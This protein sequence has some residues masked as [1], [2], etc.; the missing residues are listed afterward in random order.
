MADPDELEAP[1]HLGIMSAMSDGY[2]YYVGYLKQGGTSGISS[3]F[4]SADDLLSPGSDP[5]SAPQE[6]GFDI[7]KIAPISD[8]DAGKRIMF[9]AEAVNHDS[10]RFLGSFSVEA[11]TG[12]YGEDF[13]EL[14]RVGISN[15]A[16]KS[17]LKH[18]TCVNVY[19]LALNTGE[20]GR[21]PSWFQ[22]FIGACT[23]MIDILNFGPKV[24]QILQPYTSTSEEAAIEKAVTAV[25]HTLG[26]GTLQNIAS[27]PLREF[28]LSY[29]TQRSE[30]LRTA[31]TMPIA[32]LLEE[33]Q[34]IQEN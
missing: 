34:A 14:A 9:L 6:T 17:A 4:G 16:F 12:S 8:D 21:L 25:A 20:F 23:D 30:R 22:S 31:L 32:D 24:E 27:V 26:L 11:Q 5:K 13:T 3:I 7:N 15:K 19:L 10:R 28:L 29:K 18:L 2:K 33:L 1:E